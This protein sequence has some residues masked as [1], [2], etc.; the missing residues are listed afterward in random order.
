MLQS[1][2]KNES[3]NVKESKK[4]LKQKSLVEKSS[5]NKSRNVG[6]T[7]D[8]NKKVFSREWVEKTRQGQKTIK[9]DAC[10]QKDEFLRKI[11]E[12]ARK[13]KKEKE[14]SMEQTKQK[15]QRVKVMRRSAG[16]GSI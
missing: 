6:L 3:K 7:Q 5:G 12:E 2:I 4:D 13:N 16:I 15:R 9:N 8:S 11:A 10:D 1:T 14:V